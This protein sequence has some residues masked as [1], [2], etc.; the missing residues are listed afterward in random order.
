MRGQQGKPSS[1]DGG[2]P[3][4]HALIPC[5]APDGKRP[6]R[7][8]ADA[9]DLDTLVCWDFLL[10][11]NC[12]FPQDRIHLLLPPACGQTEAE[13]ALTLFSRR[14]VLRPGDMREKRLCDL[15]GADAQLAP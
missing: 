7:V 2:L 14:Q 9:L 1:C 4:S 13:V 10:G 5:P 3:R 8:G 11:D 12:A 6:G 15:A